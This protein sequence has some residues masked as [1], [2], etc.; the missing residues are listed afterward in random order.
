M[1]KN[2]KTPRLTEIYRL[3][4]GETLAESK[5]PKCGDPK[6]YISFMND[7]ECPNPKCVNFKGQQ[8][9]SGG[10]S[11]AQGKGKTMPPMDQNLATEAHSL[12]NGWWHPGVQE[13]AQL[14]MDATEVA[15]WKLHQD[16]IPDLEE[17][18]YYNLPAGGKPYSADEWTPEMVQV[19][20][21]AAI[22][23]EDSDEGEPIRDHVGA[24]PIA[25]T[26][27]RKI[28]KWCEDAEKV[29]G[30]SSKF[31]ALA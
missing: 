24:P 26:T 31:D 29:V 19:L 14:A 1:S 9:K 23:A 4:E 11:G 5:C 2:K 8:G 6:A 7:V 28:M 30:P 22:W 18:L 16:T 21:T 17:V 10:S 12:I 15:H 13:L 3:N 27:A 25:T 20:H